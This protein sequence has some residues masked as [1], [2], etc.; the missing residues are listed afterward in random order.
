M[1][2]LSVTAGSVV[3][4]SGSNVQG[5]AGATIT[6]GQTV[7]YDSTTT[8]YLLADANASGKDVTAGIALNGASSGQPLVV[9]TG[10]VINPGATVVV[11]TIYVQSATPGGIA[12]ST[13][14]ASGWKTT[15]LGVG[16]TAAQITVSK[17]IAS[18]VA[19]P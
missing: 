14:L 15:I 10:G 11:G 17:I 2:D 13:D 7:Y 9:F 8:T 19:V 4:V 5:T 16:T 6:A 3:M 12:P 18:G 1:A